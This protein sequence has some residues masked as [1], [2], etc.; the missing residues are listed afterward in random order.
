MRYNTYISRGVAW[1]K[2]SLLEIGIGWEGV[3]PPLVFFFSRKRTA[4]RIVNKQGGSTVLSVTIVKE[5]FEVGTV[6]KEKWNH[7]F[8]RYSKQCFGIWKCWEHFEIIEAQRCI[9]VQFKSMVLEVGTVEKN[10][11]ARTL[12]GAFSC[13]LNQYFGSWNYSDFSRSRTLKGAFWRK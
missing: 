8:W 4:E 13:I 7:A 10:F 6:E 1:A 12:N 5:V 2:W 9:L 11:K 3:I